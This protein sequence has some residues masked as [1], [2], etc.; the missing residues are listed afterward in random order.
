MNEPTGMRLWLFFLLTLPCLAGPTLDDLKW[1]SGGWVDATTEES[2]SRPAG[3]TML[4]YSRTIEDGK[5]VFF[6]YLR[7]EE[8]ADGIFYRASPLGKNETSFRLTESG[9]GLAVFSNPEHDFPKTI[10]YR[11]EGDSLTAEVSD[12][13]RTERW[14]LRRSQK[15]T[16][17]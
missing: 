5:T 9:P 8:T 6:E 12:G 15:E 4:G 10:R 11:R 16:T 1:M 2:W 7:I 3:H 13:Q 17:P 14:Q